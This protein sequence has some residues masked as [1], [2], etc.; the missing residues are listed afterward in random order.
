MKSHLY[1]IAADYPFTCFV[2]RF[3]SC[4]G[5][6]LYCSFNFN[7]VFGEQDDS[8]PEKVCPNHS[9]Q[10]A[11]DKKYEYCFNV[12]DYGRLSINACMQHG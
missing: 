7:L 2:Q 1:A 10:T 4:V 5:L 3:H 11:I 9:L 6:L 8:S 12:F